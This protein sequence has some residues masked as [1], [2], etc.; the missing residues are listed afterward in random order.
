MFSNNSDDSRINEMLYSV[1]L[2]VF[3]LSIQM[4]IMSLCFLSW[5]TLEGPTILDRIFETKY[6]NSVNLD[7]TRNV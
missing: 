1:K 7:R 3:I 4:S 6:R 2:K 5:L